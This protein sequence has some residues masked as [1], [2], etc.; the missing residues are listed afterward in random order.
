MKL[1]KKRDRILAFVVDLLIYA[2]IN[3][4]F[5]YFFGEKTPNGYQIIGFP[6]FVLFLFGIGLWPINEIFTGQTFGKKIVGLRVMNK[7]NNR[8]INGKQAFLRF[9]FGFFDIPLFLGLFVASTNKFNQRIGDLVAD[10]IVID[11]NN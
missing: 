11:L 5:Y 7:S 6:A 3:I 10:T 2:I 9:V 8:D 1:A 4:I